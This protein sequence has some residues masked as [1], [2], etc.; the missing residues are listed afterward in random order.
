MF[1]LLHRKGNRWTLN[2]LEV[3][4]GVRLASDLKCQ[5]DGL[6]VGRVDP[7]AVR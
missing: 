5:A 3:W 4:F 6:A 1:E 2:R 7:Q